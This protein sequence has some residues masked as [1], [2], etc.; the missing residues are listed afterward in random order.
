MNYILSDNNSTKILFLHGWGANKNS[1]LF[2]HNFLAS[3]GYT[4]L[5][6]DLSGFGDNP[7]L[8]RDY[9]IFD[10]ACDLKEL[11]N[12]LKYDNFFVVCHSFGARVMSIIN[13]HFNMLGVVITGGAGLKPRFSILNF[14]K[15][16]LYKLTKKIL[17]KFSF[18]KKILSKMG[19]DDYKSLDNN[20]KKTFISVV[21]THLDKYFQQIKCPCLIIWGKN[22][23]ITPLYMAKKLNRIISDSSLKI[24]DGDH[25]CFVSNNFLFSN[26]VLEFI[27]ENYAGT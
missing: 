19:S 12:S 25:F 27:K 5:S 11:L 3:Y 13:E 1:F 8:T 9:T 7:P 17:I 23:K 26:L 20:M 15:I 22:D 6:V 4:C 21:N 14:A 18:G 16:K 24:I 2:T 10:Y